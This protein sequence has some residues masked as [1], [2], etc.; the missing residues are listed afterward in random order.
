MYV[1]ILCLWLVFVFGLLIHLFKKYL[2]ADLFNKENIEKR[3]IEIQQEKEYL[4][5]KQIAINMPKSNELI[6][7]FNWGAFLIPLIWGLYFGIGKKLFLCFI[8][9]PLLPN[10]ILGIN[11]NKWAL[12]RY[13][14]PLDTYIFEQRLFI[15]IGVV[16]NLIL[17]PL[18]YESIVLR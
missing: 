15:Y 5:K 2:Y 6:D 16:L 11:A 7:K 4:S 10:I 18:I 3:K 1:F 9:I 17:L 14:R 12:S 13:Y 8:P